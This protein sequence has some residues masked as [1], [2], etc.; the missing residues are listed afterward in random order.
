MERVKRTKP[1]GGMPLQIV[2]KLHARLGVAFD[3]MVR[4]SYSNPEI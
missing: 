4:C 1:C 2:G 3:A